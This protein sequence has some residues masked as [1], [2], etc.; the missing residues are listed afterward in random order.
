MFEFCLVFDKKFA[1]D[2]S[3]FYRQDP[4]NIATTKVR[5]K[6]IVIRNLAGSWGNVVEIYTKEISNNLFKKILRNLWGNFGKNF[7]RF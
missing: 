7:K 3:Q 2:K 1:L 4:K 6:F 5:K